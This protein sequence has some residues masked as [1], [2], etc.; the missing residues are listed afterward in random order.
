MTFQAPT[1]FKEAV[2]NAVKLYSAGGVNGAIGA[3][4][5]EIE[6]AFKKSLIALKV[7]AS[8]PE[9]IPSMSKKKKKCL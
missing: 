6:P 8:K 2:D 3:D 7:S 4:W 1:L 5:A 9:V